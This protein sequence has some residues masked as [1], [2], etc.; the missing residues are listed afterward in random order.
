MKEDTHRNTWK[1]QRLKL[2]HQPGVMYWLQN[3]CRVLS[4]TT[5]T[6]LYYKESNRILTKCQ[7]IAV[8]RLCSGICSFLYSCDLQGGSP[9][10][11]TSKLSIY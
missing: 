10:T 9:S 6:E 1:I 5:G 3:I 4:G 2:L 8:F 11:Q 7:G